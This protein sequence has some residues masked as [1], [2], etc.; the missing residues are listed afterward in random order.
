MRRTSTPVSAWTSASAALRVWPSHGSGFAGPKTGS[1][2]AV[3]GA[4]VEDE[5]AALRLRHRGGDAD[6]AAEL[7]R[8]PRLAFADAL[9][10][11]RMQGIDLAPALAP[12]LVADPLGQPQQ[13]REGPA[14]ALVVGG[15]AR[16]VADHPAEPGAEEAKRPAGALELVGMDVAPDHDRRPLG[17]PQV[18]LAQLDPMPLGQRHQLDQGA[19]H[20]PRVGR[21]GDGL[22]LDGGVDRHPLQV[23]RSQRSGLVGDGQALLKQRR[24]MLLTQTLPP[25]GQRRAVEGQGVLKAQLAEQLEIRVLQPTRA[26]RLVADCCADRLAA[27]H[28]LK[29]HAPHQ[30]L[31]GA[32]GNI[33][34]LA[35]QLPPDLADAVDP[36]VLLEHAPD[37]DLE[38]LIALGPSGQPGGINA[39]GDI[40]VV[41]RRSDRQHLAD[42]LDPM[43]PTIIVDER[44][45]GFT[46]R[47]SSAWAK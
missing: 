6:L 22:G 41:G 47:S 5:L 15:L 21:M 35:L 26:Q 1:R 23:L 31:H 14:Q 24:E 29:A 42:R 39:L 30:P 40:I 17:H 43:R 8:R 27:D 12:V 37:L 10:L 32:S 18:A 4:G 34:A 46:R 44:D 33:D 20:Q 13:R 7:V 11:R 16:D 36:E 3:Q 25:A 9:D 2:V 28:P 38:S 19:M 45:H